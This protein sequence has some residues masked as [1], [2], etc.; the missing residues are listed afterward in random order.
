M[1]EE[2]PPPGFVASAVLM[3]KYIFKGPRRA[4]LAYWAACTQIGILAPDTQ[5]SAEAVEAGPGLRWLPGGRRRG[6][7]GD[8]R[9]R[10]LGGV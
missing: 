3:S 9:R 7:G 8:P 5:E 2:D 10:M 4:Q 1:D 6:N